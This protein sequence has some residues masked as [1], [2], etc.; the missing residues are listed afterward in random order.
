MS[1]NKQLYVCYIEFKKVFDSLNHK[2]L[3]SCLGQYY[4]NWSTDAQLMYSSASSC[5][6]ILYPVIK[7]LPLSNVIKES[8]SG[9]Y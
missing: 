8:D 6:K 9:V 7:P 5:V 4:W 1:Q 2:L 3:W